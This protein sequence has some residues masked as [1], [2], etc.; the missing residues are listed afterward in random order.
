MQNEHCCG[1]CKHHKPANP[2]YELEAEWLCDN[3]DSD[4]YS[5][6]TEY[7]DGEN[8]IDFEERENRK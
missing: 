3:E 6:F 7:D 1:K 2:Y 4:Y 8:C 5:C